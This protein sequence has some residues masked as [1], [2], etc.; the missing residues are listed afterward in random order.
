VTPVRAL[1]ER[2]APRYDLAN[3][4]MSAGIDQRWRRQAVALLDPRPRERLLDLACGTGD[5]AR[6]IRRRCPEA[7]VLGA[8][9]ARQMLRRA[10]PLDRLQADAL[11]LPLG[12]GSVDGVLCAFGVRNL[13]DRAAALGELARVL[14]PGGRL[15]VLELF[16]PVRA[17]AGLLAGALTR[18][19]GAWAGGDRAAYDYLAAS[20]HG[21]ITGEAFAAEL[22]AAGFAV[23]APQPLF[24]RGI[25][26]LV[27]GVRP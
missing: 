9:F 1:F 3:R 20:I 6:A 7:K 19:L 21:F 27:Q 18:T 15:V 13:D 22:R 2:L 17:G 12:K 25:A 24:P 11:A 10:G 4:V 23:A 26:A 16:H 8:D 5:C 14:R